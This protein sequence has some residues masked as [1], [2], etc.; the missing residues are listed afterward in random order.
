MAIKL[1]NIPQKPV[2]MAKPVKE[3]PDFKSLLQKDIRLFGS[4]I[5]DKIKER[6][7]SELAV[8][9]SSGIDIKSAFDIII[10]GQRRKKDAEVFRKIQYDIIK[11]E[12]LSGAMHKTG[13]FSDYEYYSIKIGEESG[14]IIEVVKELSRYFTTRI[15]QRR[16]ISGALTY[17]LLVLIVAVGV[18]VFML[19]VI[20]PMFAEVFTRF[21]GELPLITQKIM[22]LS[23]FF[24]D[25]FMWFLIAPLLLLILHKIFKRY[26]TYKK[27]Y[28]HMLLRLPFFGSLLNMVYL[29]RFCQ[30]MGLL[31][32]SKTPMLRTISLVKR[33]IGF[34][35][36]TLALGRI[37]E[38]IVKGKMLYESL[39]HFR[40]FD[41]RVVTLTKV[42]EEVNQLGEI[43]L[44]L[45]QQ[46]TEE[47]EHRMSV[48]G[49]LLEPIL[50][51]FVGV[52]VMII[53]IAMYL[54]LFQLS[55]SI[56]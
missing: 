30:S 20:V 34:Y 18:V 32:R 22:N 1:Q 6:Y 28:T 26:H 54:P 37:E 43:F 42:G 38:D 53:L 23:A 8:L 19:N 51:L 4:G 44:K 56:L 24:R 27:A 33:M 40:I 10:A 9:L 16:Q 48:M 7:Y 49:N 13:K 35:P 21:S 11:G 41:H 55:T 46:Y 5:K 36:Y 39:S 3:A 52:L 15:K 14:R 29:N 45:N 12:G 25:H 31:S 47:L 17:P 50:I 2:K